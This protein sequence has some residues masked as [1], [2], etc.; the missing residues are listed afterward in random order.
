MAR[1]YTIEYTQEAVQD[2][3]W[4]SKRD[5]KRILAGI[6]SNLRYDPTVET[7][8]RKRLRPNPLAEWE[9]RIGD[10]RVLYDV[11]KLVRVVEIQRVGEKRRSRVAFRGREVDV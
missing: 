9:L 10:F 8:N 5:Q 2:L 6:E 7:R 1:P 11:D 3:S 4:F